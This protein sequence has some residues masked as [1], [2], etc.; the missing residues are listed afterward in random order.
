MPNQSKIPNMKTIEVEI[1]ITDTL[2]LSDPKGNPTIQFWKD[3]GE[4]QENPIQI[5]LGNVWV[6]G[7]SQ[8]PTFDSGV[9]RYVTNV[10][11]VVKDMEIKHG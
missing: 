5:Q 3:L 6:Q 11:L 9:R 10:R 7:V 1:R 4:S 2:D 8:D